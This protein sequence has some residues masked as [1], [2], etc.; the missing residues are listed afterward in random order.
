M[1]V[2]YAGQSGWKGGN[3]GK[4]M[5]GNGGILNNRVSRRTESVEISQSSCL[6]YHLLF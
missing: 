2:Y 6:Q 4:S 5:D 1:G 3:R